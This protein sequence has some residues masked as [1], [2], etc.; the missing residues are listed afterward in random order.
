M[1]ILSVAVEEGNLSI[2]IEYSKEAQNIGLHKE[3]DTM[4]LEFT[5]RRIRYLY[6]SN[7]TKHETFQSQPLRK[8]QVLI[9]EANSLG[10]EEKKLK[11]LS[12]LDQTT[13]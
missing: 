6:M 4:K 3:L 10:L 11:V 12:D 5:R 1:K 9:I 2:L 13:I 8:L 7:E